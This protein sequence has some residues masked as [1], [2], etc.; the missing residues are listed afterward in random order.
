MHT[1]CDIGSDSSDIG[2]DDA[3][4][5]AGLMPESEGD[6]EPVT[7]ENLVRDLEGESA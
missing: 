2:S 6:S 5:E 1:F 3:W 7:D 4:K